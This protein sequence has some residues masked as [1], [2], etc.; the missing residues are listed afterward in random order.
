MGDPQVGALLPA[1]RTSTASVLAELAGA[2]LSDAD[3]SEPS[4]LRG[5]TRGHV[6]THLARGSDALGG[7]LA[8][9]LR[10]E[11]V[12]LYPDGD[13]GR[14]R[15]ID[16]G[17]GRGAAEIVADVRESFERLDVVLGAVHQADAWDRL[18]DRGLSNAELLVSRWCEVE[19]HRVDAGLATPA[20]WPVAF[21][22]RLLPEVVSGLAARTEQPIGVVTAGVDTPPVPEDALV[23]RGEPAEVL[24]WLL[25][26]SQPA[27]FPEVTLRP[28]RR[29]VER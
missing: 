12:P 1:L 6:L 27:D 7:T 24:A 11:V 5:W 22:R 14:S 20:D 16:A 17:A 8:G 25:G 9:T 23:V 4:L 26:R 21:V 28:W 18:A 29:F 19:I 15:D 2:A 10:G 13:T 3:M